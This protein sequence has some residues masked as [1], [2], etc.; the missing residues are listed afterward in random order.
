MVLGEMAD[1]VL[2]GSRVSS[3]KL[4]NARYNFLFSNLEDTLY[5]VIY[6]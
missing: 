2:K 5:D 1:V 6:N 4:K 3:V